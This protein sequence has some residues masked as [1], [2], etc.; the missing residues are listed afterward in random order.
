MSRLIALVLILCTTCAVSAQQ[1]GEGLQKAMRAMRDGNWAA[2]RIEARTDGRESLD[3]ILWHY[4]RAGNGDAQL[5]MDFLARNPNWP[6]L[7]YLKENVEIAMNEARRSQIAAFY[8]GYTPRTGSGALSLARVLKAQGQKTQA[9]EVIKSAWTSLALSSDERQAFLNDWKKL[10]TPLHTE[11]LDMALWKGWAKNAA[12]MVPLVDKDWQALAEARLALRA[13]AP[14]V[15]TLIGKVPEALQSDPGL[16]FERFNWRYRKGRRAEAVE[17][18]LERS[19]S[20]KLLGQAEPWARPRRDLVRRQMRAGNHKVAY[21]LASQHGLEK[22]SNFADLEWLS[23]YLALRFLNKPD[24]ALT[25]FKRF[26]QAVWTP[27]SLGRAGYWQGRAHEALGNKKAARAAYAEGAKFQTSFYGLLAA[28]RGGIAPDPA[29][30]GTEDFGDWRQAEFTRSS[31]FRAAIVLLRAG[32]LDLAER[33]L[34]HLSEGLDRQGKGQLGSMLIQ[35][36]RPH[37]QVMLGK[38]AAQESIELPGP[39]YALHPDLVARDFA[40]PKELVLAISRRESEFDPKVISGAGARGLMQLMPRTAKEVSSKLDLAYGKDKLLTDPAYNATLG[41]AYLAELSDRFGGNAVMMS[42]GY[43]AGPSRPEKWM[44]QFGNPLK[45]RM[46]IV[47]WIEHIPFD[48]TRNYVMRVT[49]SLP[50]YRAR[51]GQPPHPVT[52][53]K[54]LVGSTM[55]VGN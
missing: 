47:D 40:V 39:Y 43:N 7:P 32:E 52:F 27:I 23:G 22:G 12:A 13:Q 44:G 38:R 31:V 42:A 25:H 33:F 50:V 16:A 1:T 3:V 41:A 5:A 4:L 10:V 11:R 9:E 2:A 49:E 15:D 51:L 46:D 54:E 48:E 37:I 45:G 53:S 18:L 20:A 17:L 34:T 19:K 28:E 14:G 24:Q 35:M 8:D 29:L 21:Q 36:R 6:G 26:R 30:A 55:K